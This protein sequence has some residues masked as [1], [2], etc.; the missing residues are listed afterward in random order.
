MYADGSIL[1]IVDSAGWLEVD[2]YVR[3]VT[4]YTEKVSAA[5]AMGIG[6]NSVA[7]RETIHRY[8]T[9]GLGATD[10]EDDVQP[11]IQAR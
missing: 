5:L 7:G 4:T 8:I 2:T 9:A 1:L 6:D 3:V 11:G 10:I